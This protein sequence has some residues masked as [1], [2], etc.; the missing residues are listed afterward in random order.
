[1][2]DFLQD[3][4]IEVKVMIQYDFLSWIVFLSHYSGARV[5]VREGG[6]EQMLQLIRNG[7][8]GA[9]VSVCIPCNVVLLS[10]TSVNFNTPP[11]TMIALL[12]QNTRAK[13]GRTNKLP[14]LKFCHDDL[15]SPTQVEKKEETFKSADFTPCK[16][17]RNT[18]SLPTGS[19]NSS[20]HKEMPSSFQANSTSVLLS[21]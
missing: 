2:F 8:L 12:M 1:M 10:T 3:R 14:F 4:N 9:T 13:R 16:V 19:P 18:S 11:L 7:R 17:C 20:G 6:Y 15:R 5:R 21:T